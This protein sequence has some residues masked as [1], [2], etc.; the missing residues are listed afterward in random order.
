MTVK[1]LLVALLC[2]AAARGSAA[3]DFA[4]DAGCAVP[5]ARKAPKA[6]L[7][8][9]FTARDVTTHPSGLVFLTGS[10][11]IAPFNGAFAATTICLGADGAIAWTSQLDHATWG[12]ATG[13][14]V[15]VDADGNSYVTTDL[16]AGHEFVIAKYA[17]DGSE[18]WVVQVADHVTGPEVFHLPEQIHVDGTGSVR[19]LA[20]LGRFLSLTR[21]H[22][23]GSEQW[24]IGIDPVDETVEAHRGI[25]V[26]ALGNSYF[27]HFQDRALVVSKV[28]A[29]GSEPWRD[30]IHPADIDTYTGGDLVANDAGDT[31]VACPYEE[32][33]G[34]DLPPGVLLVKHA[35]GG[36][37]L[38]S[39]RIEGL[40][41]PT[42]PTPQVG[43]LPGVLACDA[44]GAVYLFGTEDDL[45]AT[46]VTAVLRKYSADGTLEWTQRIP[47]PALA[48]TV[49]GALVLDLA[50]NA[51]AVTRS[52]SP[53]LP[54]RVVSFDP[55]G[56]LRWDVPLGDVLGKSYDWAPRAVAPLAAG[57]LLLAGPSIYGGK[58]KL[59]TGTVTEPAAAAGGTA[60]IQQALLA[61]G[62]VKLGAPRKLKVLKVRNLSTTECLAVS[63]APDAPFHAAG[64]FVLPP[65]GKLS[66]KIAFAPVAS[67]PAQQTLTVLTSDPAHPEIQVALEGEGLAP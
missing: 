61:F 18:A 65:H 29:N 4:P 20:T 62:K 13:L 22:P 8:K 45:P 47:S 50:G 60:S 19:I 10:M 3:Q 11:S 12:N 27:A 43:A 6:A 2:L 34:F 37:Q 57:G 38:W 33:V 44:D 66:V 26:D 35:T 52:T 40:F 42:P 21:L 31:W 51:V 16:F 58:P 17:P 67:G 55:A 14:A 56:R 28:G 1:P 7:T 59:V 5:A 24:I 64:P 36:A 30:T 41:L 53:A 63:L 46:E 25:G 39:K 32:R 15:A 9:F 54:R 23:D 48:S 49:A